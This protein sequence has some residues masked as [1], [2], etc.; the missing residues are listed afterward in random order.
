MSTARINHRRLA[1]LP[2]SVRPQTANEAYQCQAGLVSQILEHFG[3]E[4]IGYKI[5]CTN[6]LAQQQLHVSGPFYGHLLSRFCFESPA[7]IE[8]DQFF[9]RV[10]EAEFAFRMRHDLPPVAQPY[11]ED[12]I[13]TAVEGVLPAIEIVDSRFMDWT[14][15]GVL[16]LISDNA[17]NGAWVKG[18]L[19]RNWQEINLAG[20]PVQLLVN[21]RIVCKGSGAAVMG[22]PLHALRWLVHTLCSSGLGLK[23]GQYISTGVTTDVYMAESGDRITADFGE[24]GCVNLKFN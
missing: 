8:A 6:P 23:G 10:V 1:E 14:T 20:Q 5:A 17:C 11:T 9:M 16:S 22:H 4:V 15:I 18:P 13:A 7:Q 12:E 2:Y 21:G 24:V 19:V 3:G